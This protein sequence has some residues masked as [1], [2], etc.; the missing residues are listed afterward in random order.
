MCTVTVRENKIGELSSSLMGNHKIFVPSPKHDDNDGGQLVEH[1]KHKWESHAHGTYS[2]AVIF[3]G[4]RWVDK[5][6]K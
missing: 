6:Q 3:A 1:S 2:G 5:K 4:S